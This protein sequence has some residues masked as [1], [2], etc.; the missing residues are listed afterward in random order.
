VAIRLWDQVL[1]TAQLPAILA[2]RPD[3]P[4][5]EDW[6]LASHLQQP[7]SRRKN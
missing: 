2:L 3:T 5:L 4:S 6:L 7:K 1:A